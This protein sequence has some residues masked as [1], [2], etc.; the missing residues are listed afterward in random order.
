[1]SIQDRAKNERIRETIGA[2][3]L[4]ENLRKR[5]REVLIEVSFQSSRVIFGACHV[6]TCRMCGG[7]D[8]NAPQDGQYHGIHAVQHTEYCSVGKLLKEL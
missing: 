6:W 1:M 4:G 7:N 3:A 8:V 5:V 2:L